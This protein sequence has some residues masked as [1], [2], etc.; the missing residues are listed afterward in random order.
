VAKRKCKQSCTFCRRGCTLPLYI[1]QDCG[2]FLVER[3]V[4][5]LFRKT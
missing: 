3:C 4:F 5:Q 2:K 1:V